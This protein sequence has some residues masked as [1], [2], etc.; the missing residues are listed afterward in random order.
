MNFRRGQS[1]LRADLRQWKRLW[2]DMHSTDNGVKGNRIAFE[3]GR[4]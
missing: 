4:T 3:N 2:W 1:S